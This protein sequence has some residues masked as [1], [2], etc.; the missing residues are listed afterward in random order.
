VRFTVEGS[1]VREWIAKLKAA[2]DAAPDGLME[3]VRESA[4][5]QG[6]KAARLEFLRRN[7][8]PIAVAASS[9]WYSILRTCTVLAAAVETIFVSSV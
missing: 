8:L 2:I 9:Q 7:K 1:L 5:Q 6:G 3:N 4:S